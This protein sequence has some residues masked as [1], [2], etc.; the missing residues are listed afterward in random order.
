MPYITYLDINGVRGDIAVTQEG[1]GAPTSST[2]GAIGQLYLDTGA[3]KMYQCTAIKGSAYTWLPL[4]KTE[5]W[6]FELED[7]STVTK[8]VAVES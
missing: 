5:T 6:T 2:V 3:G 7:G 4:I 1:S 8:N